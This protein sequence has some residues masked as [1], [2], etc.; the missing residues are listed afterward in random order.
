VDYEAFLAA[1]EGDAGTSREL[2]ER[3]VRATLQTLA[4][5]LSG[6]EAEDLAEQLPQELRPFFRDGNKAEPFDLAEFVRRVAEREGVP[7]ETAQEH[8]RAVFAALG[9]ALTPEELHDMASQLPKDFDA[10]VSAAVE[11]RARL[12]AWA[13]RAAKVT[14][15]EFYERVA[16]RAGLERDAARRATDAVLEALAYRISGGEVDDLE[17]YLPPELH[18][19]LEAGKAESSGRAHK[20]SLDDF[21]QRIAERER[22]TPAEA[23]VH[24]HAVLATLHEVAPPEFHDVLSELPLDYRTLLAR[25]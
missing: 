13:A 1:V 14:A 21:L 25:A 23:R 22:V 6:G 18:V 3:A 4:E 5:R 17:L 12:R 20:L 8:A 7:P 2:A 19:P 16:Q 11:A 9:M 15:D 10:L 24:A